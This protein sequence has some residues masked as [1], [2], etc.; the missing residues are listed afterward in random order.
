MHSREF[1][2]GPMVHTIFVFLCINIL[3][4]HLSSSYALERIVT[5]ATANHCADWYTCGSI[6]EISYEK[7]ASICCQLTVV[8]NLLPLWGFSEVVWAKLYWKPDFCPA[9]CYPLMERRLR[10][11]DSVSRVDFNFAEGNAKLVWK[12]NT[13]YDDRKIRTPMAWVGVHVSDVRLKIRGVIENDNKDLFIVSLGGWH[14]NAIIKPSKARG[15]ALSNESH[16]KCLF[17]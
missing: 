9:T 11:I 4:L 13:P 14:T 12:P 10:Q 1:T 5:R 7:V 15:R 8:L 2:A 17:A 6:E 16:T 3:E